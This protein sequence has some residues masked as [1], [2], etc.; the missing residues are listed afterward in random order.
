MDFNPI[1]IGHLVKLFESPFSLAIKSKLFTIIVKQITLQGYYYLNT[2]IFHELL[3]R[4]ELCNAEGGIKVKVAV[5]YLCG[6][7]LN[8]SEIEYKEALLG[9][10][11][12]I[13]INYFIEFYY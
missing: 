13:F 12:V 7:H 11:F 5:S 3:G 9:S 4:I 6:W 1:T 8:Y 2:T 10:E